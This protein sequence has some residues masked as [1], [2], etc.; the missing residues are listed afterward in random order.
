MARTTRGVSERE[1]DK[2]RES[3][4]ERGRERRQ[5]G[6]G[7]CRWRLLII[8]ETVISVSVSVF[9][10]LLF[11]LFWFVFVDMWKTTT[12]RSDKQQLKLFVIYLKQ[13][14]FDKTNCSL[15]NDDRNELYA[16]TV[17]AATSAAAA[18]AAAAAGRMQWQGQATDCVVNSIKGNLST[19]TARTTTDKKRNKIRF[20]NSL[21]NFEKCLGT[22]QGC[23][24]L[25]KLPPSLFLTRYTDI[26][27]L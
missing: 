22:S 19:T 2:G 27:I 17:S 20:T 12:K 10:L 13:R 4:R 14:K 9:S 23:S 6:G 21:R 16:W 15:K 5:S 3:E 11:F 7:S 1:E 8:W 25:R 24:Q 26:H 18:A